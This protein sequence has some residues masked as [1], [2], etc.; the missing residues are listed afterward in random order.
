MARGRRATAN[1][2]PRPSVNLLNTTISSAG[3]FGW[4][5]RWLPLSYAC[6][7]ALIF[8]LLKVREQESAGQGGLLSASSWRTQPP[9]TLGLGEMKATCYY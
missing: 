5:S 4:D 2:T 8:N 3:S 9:L 1:T 7:L 6:L